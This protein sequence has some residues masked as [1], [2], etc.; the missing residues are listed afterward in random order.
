M[1]RT[2]VLNSLYLNIVQFVQ[3][4]AHGQFRLL[5]GGNCGNPAVRQQLGSWKLWSKSKHSGAV[6]RVRRYLDV[7]IGVESGL[8]TSMKTSTGSF[9]LIP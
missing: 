9:V 7:Y 4:E 2:M 3:I 6:F 5:P 8:L 1:V